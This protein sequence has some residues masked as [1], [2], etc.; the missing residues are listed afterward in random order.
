MDRNSIRT[1]DERL[2]RNRLV[3][4]NRLKRAKQITNEDKALVP[5]N[6]NKPALVNL[7]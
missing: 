3:E 2:E 6:M 4:A 5:V 7:F 1:A